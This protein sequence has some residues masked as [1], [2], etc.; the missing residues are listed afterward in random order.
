MNKLFFLFELSVRELKKN[1]KINLIVMFSL[2]LGLMM[3]IIALANINV[4]WVNVKNLFPQ[5]SENAY[6]CN[7]ET[8][9]LTNEMY[10]EI[11]ENLDAIKLGGCEKLAYDVEIT[12]TIVNDAVGAISEEFLDFVKY[13]I[14]EGRSIKKEEIKEVK[15]V[16]MIEES[17]LSQYNLQVGVG[18]VLFVEGKPLQIVGVF[19]SMELI[20][21][22]LVPNG[23]FDDNGNLNKNNYT[24][25]VQ[26]EKNVGEN[27]IEKKLE[28]K[29]GQIYRIQDIN[30]YFERKREICFSNSVFI[31]AIT[32]P[33]MIFSI[34]NCI[35]VL[36]GKIA[37]MRYETGI[38]MAL[39]AEKKEIFFSC[40]FENGLL[41]LLA[42]LIDILVLP[43]F[44][45]T[46]PEGVILLFDAKVYVLGFL[47]LE[48]LCFI[49]SFSMTHK[50]MKFDIASVL[51][52][53]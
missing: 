5:I 19:R 7:V 6:F 14:I 15:T 37:R 53:E 44:T 46:I 32:I 25:F 45:Q 28:E 4:F 8:E 1:I 21:K 18:D 39:G 35:L 30:D 34:I 22:V 42:Y 47:I 17:L 50:I 23:V 41:S 51:K 33:L 20:N 16:C 43:M 26:T 36:Y 24:F 3:P 38:K 49:I 40:F 10:L 13:D 12:D 27:Q 2:A 52:G 31:F 11:K 9:H 29:T 48:L